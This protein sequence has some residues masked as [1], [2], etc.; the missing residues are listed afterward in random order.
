M[1]ETMKAIVKDKAAPGAR[2]MEVP[3]PQVGPKD[4]LVEVKATSICGTDLHIFNWDQWA[5]SRIKPPMVFGHEFSGIVLEVGDMVT[6]IKV[7]DHVSAETH[8]TCG[9]CY[10]CRIGM[11]HYCQNCKIIG[12]DV[13]GTFAEYA[14]IPDKVAWVNDKSIPFEIAS[15]QEPMGNAIYATTDGSPITGETVAIFGCG[16]FGQMACAVAKQAGAFKVI[17]I[18]PNEYRAQAALKLGA[19]SVINPDKE[20]LYSRIAELTDRAEV[21]VVLEMSGHPKAIRDGFKLLRNGGRIT[22]FGIPSQP[23]TLD[24]PQDI[25]FKSAH[26]IGI[27]GRKIFETWF[28]VAAFLRS[29]KIDIRPVITHQFK[30][31]EFEEAMALMKEGRSGKIVMHP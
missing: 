7:G 4:V 3:V 15:I 28:Q 25:I 18:E 24:L 13:P 21:D 31:E 20:D 26:V 12:V 29:S 11:R 1:Q 16:P 6:D 9:R 8:I 14:V 27:T 5:Q 10:Q 17:A 23:I 30:L 22:L 19:D 2:L